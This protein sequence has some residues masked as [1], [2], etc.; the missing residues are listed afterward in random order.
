MIF[1][2]KLKDHLSKLY[3]S[4]YLQP[5]RAQLLLYCLYPPKMSKQFILLIDSKYKIG[6]IL[7]FNILI[8][9]ITSFVFI[10][11]IKTC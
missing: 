3:I 5:Y 4:I 2:F 9:Q 1:G 10:P 11:Y 8:L 6:L 7:F